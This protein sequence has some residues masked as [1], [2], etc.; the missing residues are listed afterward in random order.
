MGQGSE[1]QRMGQL[2]RNLELDIQWG[3]RGVHELVRE[4]V[5][6]VVRREFLKAKQIR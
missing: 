6:R 2:R 4:G 3:M 1:L 5:Q